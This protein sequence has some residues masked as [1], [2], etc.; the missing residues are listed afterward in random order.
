MLI[1]ILLLLSSIREVPKQSLFKEPF[2]LCRSNGAS[3][4]LKDCVLM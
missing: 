1:F 2:K 4:I 3:N